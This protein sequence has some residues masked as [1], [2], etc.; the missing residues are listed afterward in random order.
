MT[1]T[2]M[3]F[4]SQMIAALVALIITL[5]AG[6]AATAQDGGTPTK[7]PAPPF[8]CSNET[9][10]GRFATRGGGVA[11]ANPMDPASPLV[12]FS[13]V[14]LMTFDGEGGLTNAAVNSNNGSIISGSNPGTYE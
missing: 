10:D 5:A 2:R 6:S 12:P 13:N 7:S 1:K 14:S 9:L 8:V 11:P 3:T 4:Y